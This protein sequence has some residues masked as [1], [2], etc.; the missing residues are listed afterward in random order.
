MELEFK[1]KKFLFE[2]DSLAPNRFYFFETTGGKRVFAGE[3][4]LVLEGAER[5]DL[6]N[7]KIKQQYRGAVGASLFRGA[8]KFIAQQFPKAQTVG[9]YKLVRGKEKRQGPRTVALERFRRARHGK[10]P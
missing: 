5:V 6:R 4:I 1:G 10:P 7:I 2:R 9:Y 8:L 3:G